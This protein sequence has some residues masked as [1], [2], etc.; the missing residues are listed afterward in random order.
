[1]SNL[2]TKTQRQSSRR[3]NQDRTFSRQMMALSS[4]R[5]IQH[6]FSTQPIRS[7]ARRESEQFFQ[8]MLNKLKPKQETL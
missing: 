5:A 8:D 4:S 2:I 6:F 7:K 1:M 3:Y